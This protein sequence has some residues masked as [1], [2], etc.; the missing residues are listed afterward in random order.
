MVQKVISE[1]GKKMQEL[2]VCSRRRGGRWKGERNDFLGYKYLFY[3]KKLNV[4][5]VEV[6][7]IKKNYNLAWD[8]ILI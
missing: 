5:E 1:A 3:Q 6:V 4:V 8:H 2:N 7:D